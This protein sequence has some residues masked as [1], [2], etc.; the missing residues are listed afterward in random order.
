MNNG[1]DTKRLRHDIE[2]ILDWGL[3]NYRR[4]AQQVWE[5]IVDYY[6]GLNAS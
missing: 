3:L 1:D 4:R 2:N 6:S 5:E